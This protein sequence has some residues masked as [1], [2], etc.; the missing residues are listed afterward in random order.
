MAPCTSFLPTFRVVSIERPATS[1]CAFF[2]DCWL[3]SD[4]L[5]LPINPHSKAPRNGSELYLEDSLDH[6]AYCP[7]C[8]ALALHCCEKGPPSPQCS[9]PRSSGSKVCELVHRKS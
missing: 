5:H 9:H 1:K 6:Y 7:L 2:S 8:C 3:I 4:A